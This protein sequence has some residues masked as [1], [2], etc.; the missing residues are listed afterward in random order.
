MYSNHY[1]CMCI[2]SKL[3]QIE[4]VKNLTVEMNG[5]EGLE[6]GHHGEAM[7]YV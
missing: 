5:E 1:I 7:I 6:L 4:E 2:K 3:V